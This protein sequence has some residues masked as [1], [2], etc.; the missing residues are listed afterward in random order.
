MSDARWT[1]IDAAVASATRYFSWAV[2]TYP[3]MDTASD[4][5]LVG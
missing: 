2:G 3:T 5:Y 1:E 4:P